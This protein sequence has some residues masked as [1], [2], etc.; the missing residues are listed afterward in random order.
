MAATLTAREHS[1][2]HD[3]RIRKIRVR[4][5]FGVLAEGWDDFADKRGDILF[6]GVIYPAVGLI[7]AAAA[8]NQNLL[9]FVFPLAAG[10]TLLGPAVAS[11]FYELARR[12]ECGDDPTWRHF[13][14]VIRSD[15][16]VSI[17]ALTIVLLAIFGLW[18]S[19]A[20]SIYASTLGP[21]P[22][23]SIGQFLAELFGTEQGWR[24]IIIG[25]LVG[26]L[27]A[28]L[29]LAISVVSFPMLVD[30]HVSAISAVEASVRATLRNPLPIAVWGLIVATLLV[31]GSIPFFVGLAVVLPLLGYSTWHLYRRLVEY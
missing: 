8:L 16:I 29:V 7:A 4:D 30:R 11:G 28:A 1:I 15:S 12:R 31:L 13:L 27:F 17:L 21:E 9:P 5:L 26:F 19:S 22:P 3:A 25:N 20:W 14:D 23:A 24:L 6:I 18:I 2:V 10:L